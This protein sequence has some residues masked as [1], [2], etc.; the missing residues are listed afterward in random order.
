MSSTLHCARNS[1][2]DAGI[3]RRARQVFAID[4]MLK[5]FTG[6]VF[7]FTTA[8]RFWDWLVCEGADAIVCICLGVLHVGRHAIVAAEDA[9]ACLAAVRGLA[10]SSI[11]ADAV[12]Q[13]ATKQLDD[14]K[15]AHGGRAGD[16]LASLRRR[17]EAIVERQLGKRAVGKLADATGLTVTEA[18]ALRERFLAQTAPGDGSAGRSDAAPTGGASGGAEHGERAHLVDIAA[19]RRVLAEIA[20]AWA[21]DDE[22]AVR[23]FSTFDTDHSGT[24]SLREFIDGLTALTGNDVD[25][26]LSAL[27]SIVDSNDN[28]VIERVELTTLLN[29]CYALLLPS[30]P[31]AA[32]GNLATALFDELDADRDGGINEQEWKRVVEL[33]PLLVESLVLAAAQTRRKEL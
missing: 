25:A 9:S 16:P 22:F 29:R 5:I 4:W 31:A 33:Q 24:I 8:V 18:A 1:L 15:R 7:P 6:G 30:V 20:P 17:A 27:F 3:A 12:I 28:G 2:A 32:V 13:H 19:F 10:S 11:D 14:F 21:A 26:Q 23:L